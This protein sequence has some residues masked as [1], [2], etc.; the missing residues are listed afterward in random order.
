MKFNFA[1]LLIYLFSIKVFSQESLEN[2]LSEI[3]LQPEMLVCMFCVLFLEAFRGS[4]GRSWGIWEGSGASW[5][6]F[7]SSELRLRRVLGAS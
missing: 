1:F 5:A 3:D 7:G 4:F 6:V 2:I